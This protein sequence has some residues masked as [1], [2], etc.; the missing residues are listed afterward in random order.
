[1]NNFILTVMKGKESSGR[2]I[3]LQT[4][5]IIIV[6]LVGVFVLFAAAL[7]YNFSGEK[8]KQRILLQYRIEQIETQSYKNYFEN[9]S[10]D[11]FYDQENLFG[12]GIYRSDG[13][14]VYQKGSALGF[15]PP[16]DHSF[17]ISFD[18]KNRSLT[19]VRRFGGPPLREIEEWTEQVF[20]F[21]S[22]K[23]DI[24]R[25]PETE[26]E[27][28]KG[29][30]IP[31]DIKP[32]IEE[33]G[34]EAEEMWKTIWE[35]RGKSQPQTIYY[36]IPVD[37][38][39]QR[40]ML[41]RLLLGSILLILLIA[42]FFARLIIRRNIIYRRT[43]HEQKEAVVLGEAARTL[44]HEIKSPLSAIR[45]QADLLKRSHPQAADREIGII[46][47]EVD[48]LSRL[49]GKIREFLSSS[50]GRPEIVN[51]NG[52]VQNIAERLPGPFDL[53]L[54]SEELP[55]RIDRDRFTSV[56]ENI[57]LNGR[58]SGGADLPISIQ[59]GRK[60]DLIFISIRDQ[61]P[62]IP[63]EAATHIFEPFYTS[64]EQGF[65]IGLTIA[66]RFIKA[67]GGTISAKNA[68]AG[69]AKI[70]IFLPEYQL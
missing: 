21:R 35:S 70:T 55:V 53:V 41:R 39:M 54:E 22:K 69:G 10:L 27:S 64:K 65:G 60:K 49:A 17:S 40:L 62:G 12:F 43:L 46:Y 59:T 16:P 25:T 30:R 50:E 13:S 5:L 37:T 57:I 14:P 20:S 38:Y 26:N 32:L 61:G 52:M 7:L 11:D 8:M 58:E 44:V 36:E 18:A 28:R 45:L 24:N 1:M 19:I 47:E 68:E 3:S 15:I 66:A 34:P 2:R 67:A 6:S 33:I 56:L 51:V 9:E 4:D 42:G 23:L 48:R 63:R 31:P 29:F